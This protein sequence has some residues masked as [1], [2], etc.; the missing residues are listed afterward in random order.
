MFRL[1]RLRGFGSDAEV[2]A[3]N[4]IETLS[5][6][7]ARALDR[8]GLPELE[9]PRRLTGGANMESWRFVAGEYDY[10]LRRAPSAALMADRPFGHD[11]EAA[12]IRAAR[13]AGVAA[14]E[15][16]VELEA[17]DAIGSG[18][19]MRA[20]P[21]TPD[22]RAILEGDDPGTLL[23]DCARELA[24]TH[25]VP[26]QAL[27]RALPEPSIVD[28]QSDLGEQ[29][30]AAGGDRP[31]IALALRWL[32]TNRPDPPPRPGLVHGDFRLGN[33]LVGDG[34]LT[35]VLD[36]ELAH[37]GDPHED[38]AYAMLAVWRFGRPDR[39]ALGL[40]SEDDWI[41][42]YE[43]AGGTPVDRTRLRYW[44]VHRTC[45]W[46]LGCLRMAAMWRTGQDRSLERVVIARRA[47]EQELDL[48]RLLEREA[49][50][51]ERAR[52]LPLSDPAH[53][54]HGDAS[55]G[56]IASAVSEW[57]A[58]LKPRMEGHDRFQLAVARNALG[59]V[60]RDAGAPDPR[61]SVL[62]KR[63]MDGAVDL[64]EPGLFARLKRAALD[65]CAADSP[66][67]PPLALARAAWEGEH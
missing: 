16:V 32:E 38:L 28:L 1:P 15:I 53:E 24:K 37:L 41:A 57:L 18:F 55:V 46:A 11:T 3:G 10:V 7:L 31:I 42:A 19:V 67:Y 2:T 6:G 4:D 14:P 27:P 35:G 51:T 39:A 30:A 20:I 17:G 65:R 13:A 60:A 21:G 34:R 45:W 47:A 25:A 48:L 23:A 59:I 64:A 29:F 33:L 54:L 12:I 40:G 58:T 26:R 50:E 61:D 36:W 49:P 22:P 52:P 9:Q 56:E 8:A 66:K 5:A 43:A 63:L 62:S 44:L